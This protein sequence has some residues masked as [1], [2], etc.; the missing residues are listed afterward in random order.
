MQKKYFPIGQ[1]ALCR[2]KALHYACNLPVVPAN[3]TLNKD[4]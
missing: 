3:T 4:T 2:V 1:S